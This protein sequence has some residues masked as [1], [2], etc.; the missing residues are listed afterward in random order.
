MR[1]KHAV[2]WERAKRHAM[3]RLLLLLFCAKQRRYYYYCYYETILL[4]DAICSCHAVCSFLNMTPLKSAQRAHIY[5][6]YMPN[7]R[8]TN[9]ETKTIPYEFYMRK[10]SAAYSPETEYTPYCNKEAALF[11]YAAVMPLPVGCRR[12]HIFH[13]WLNNI[14]YYHWAIRHYLTHMSLPLPLRHLFAVTAAT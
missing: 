2:I 5:H 8:T 10:K 12:R 11:Q 9:E 6:A 13:Y 1:A 7:A 3:K 4:W 14:Y